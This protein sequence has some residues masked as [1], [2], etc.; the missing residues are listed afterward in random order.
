MVTV[1]RAD[2]L[3]FVIFVNDHSPA[4]VHVFGDG[5]VKIDLKG[6]HGRPRL[7]WADRMSK[8]DIRRAMQIVEARQDELSA[9]WDEFHG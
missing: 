5:E 8:A 2:G 9:R 4:H 7:V 6:P 1:Y 3:R